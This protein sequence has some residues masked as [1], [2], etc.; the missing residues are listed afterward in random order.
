M[1]E[2]L[3]REQKA[4]RLRNAGFTF[5]K[6]NS[7]KSNKS[8]ESDKNLYERP[9]I[10]FDADGKAK[11]NHPIFIDYFEKNINYFIIKNNPYEKANFFLYDNGVY[12]LCDNDY[13]KSY[14]KKML[15]LEFRKPRIINPLVEDLFYMDDFKNYDDCNPENYIN[16]KNGLYNLDTRKLEQHNPDI[17]TTRQINSKYDP[18]ADYSKYINGAF[19]KFINHFVGGDQSQ[20]QLI[21]EF[22]GVAISNIPVYRYKKA[23]FTV[24]EGD[25]GKS[26]LPKL[27]QNLIGK[28]NYYSCKLNKLETSRF[29]SANLYNKRLAAD[30]DM[31]FMHVKELELFKVLTGGDEIDAEFKGQNGFNFIFDGLLWFCTNKLPQFG[32]DKGDHVYKRFCI[33]RAVGKTYPKGDKPIDGAVEAD[34]KILARMIRENPYIIHRALTALKVLVENQRFSESHKQMEAL[35]EYKKTNSSVMQFVDD[36]IIERPTK[37]DNGDY[38]IEDDVTRARIYNVYIKWCIENQEY[39]EKKGD[40]F[41]YIEKQGGET[42][43]HSDGIYYFKKY[44]ISPEIKKKFNVFDTT[45]NSQE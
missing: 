42:F 6:G 2:K 40:L 25:T 4:D 32:G 18:D 44:T 16:F 37:K 3:T 43:K 5:E 23:L 24:G 45:R 31:T 9:Y 14:V 11:F 15:P 30:P 8:D 17:L 13:L 10:F 28:R 27:I 39:K 38:K 21:L 36:C 22:I 35:D 41:D 12:K 33:I 26:Q 34:P 29:S 19:D 1:N 20:I 7:N